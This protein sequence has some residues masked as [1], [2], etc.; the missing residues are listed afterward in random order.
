MKVK[1]GDLD[2]R[3]PPCLLNHCLWIPWWLMSL[4]ARIH[5]QCKRPGFNYWVGKISWRRE[6]QPTPVIFP[7]KFHGKRSLVGYSLW[8]C[9]ELDTAKWLAL[10]LWSFCLLG[11]FSSSFSSDSEAFCIL[12][13]STE[14]KLHNVK[15]KSWAFWRLLLRIIAQ[16]IAS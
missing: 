11:T 12:V 5:L 15:V 1:H 13:L 4:P 16:E 8:G 3:P 6:W 10:S 9:R 14:W 2:S 7:G